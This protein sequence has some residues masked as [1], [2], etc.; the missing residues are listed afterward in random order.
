MSL[1]IIFSAKYLYLI[2]LLLVIIFVFVSNSKNRK[3]IAFLSFFS[4]PFSLLN[5]KILNYFIYNPRPFVVKNLEPLITHAA[6]NGF[7]SDHTLLCATVS[8][9]VFIFNKKWGTT[10]FLL[11]LIVGFSRVLA[12]VHHPIDIIASTIIAIFSVY[13]CWLVLKSKKII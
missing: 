10:L 5:G 1:L 6:D 13:I 7:P 12:L 2:I 8:S 11:T 3:N 9:V 4:L